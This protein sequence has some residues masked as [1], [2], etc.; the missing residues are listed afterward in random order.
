MQ[1]K[2]EAKTETEKYESK[3]KELQSEIE[4][5]RHLVAT[6]SHNAIIYKLQETQKN[7]D[8]KTEKTTKEMHTHFQ[9]EK[10]L[11]KE[12]FELQKAISSLYDKRDEK[13]F[14]IYRIKLSQKNPY[15]SRNKIKELTSQS[16]KINIQLKLQQDILDKK[17]KQYEDLYK[18]R[19]VFESYFK[20]TAN[21]LQ[22]E[23][24]RYLY[25][26]YQ[27][28]IENM[29][30][31]HQ[32]ITNMIT[33]NKRDLKIQKILEQLKIRDEYIS[34]ENA[35]LQK[36]KVNFSFPNENEIKQI[37]QLKYN[38]TKHIAPL[39]VY[40]DSNNINEN[41][42]VN[43]NSNILQNGRTL[44]GFQSNK[45]DY[46][47]YSNPNVVKEKK[48]FNTKTNEIISYI[49]GRKK[50]DVSTLRL[51]II[52]NKFKGSKVMYVGGSS[53][54]NNNEYNDTNV[55]QFRP[56]L[57]NKSNSNISIKSQS[58][59][60]DVIKNNQGGLNDRSIYKIKKGLLLKKD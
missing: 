39:Y 8:T 57:L 36:R 20:K 28:Q 38:N 23:S 29:E 24:L 21:N 50:K 1:V 34:K 10:S 41:V 54:K 48:V 4:K 3:I 49:A 13:K 53:S 56:G 46:S 42:N 60:K 9:Q 44:S 31:E 58:S 12:I 35:E 26:Y 17:L 52:N 37:S 25:E 51:N 11:K 32:R 18:K 16:T 2:E 55:I 6:Q 5:Y 14:Q 19:E 43:N 27:L 59:D 40:Q 47:H 7:Q 22:V 45:M 30:N 33:L 15:S